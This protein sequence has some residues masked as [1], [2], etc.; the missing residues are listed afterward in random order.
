MLLA[1]IVKRFCT[2][3]A[4]GYANARVSDAP[5]RQDRDQAVEG[6]PNIAGVI[7]SFFIAALPSRL[8][9]TP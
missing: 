1:A 5:A 6:A 4:S 7:V 9:G 2:W 3:P 8:S